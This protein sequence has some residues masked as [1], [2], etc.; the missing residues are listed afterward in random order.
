LIT[1]ERKGKQR[2]RTKKKLQQVI[3]SQRKGEEKDHLKKTSLGPLR[4]GQQLD[5]TETK[6]SSSNKQTPTKQISK[7][8]RTALTHMQDPPKPMQPLLN[9]CIQTSSQNIA[10]ASAQLCLVRLVHSIGQTS[11]QHLHRISTMTGWTGD[12]NRLDW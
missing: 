12:H 10:A 8:Q 11:A 3:E 1:K 9:E 2:K 5:T 4:Q 7:P 6:T